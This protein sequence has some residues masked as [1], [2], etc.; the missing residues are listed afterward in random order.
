MISNSPWRRLVGIK[1]LLTDEV[2]LEEQADSVDLVLI[3][4]EDLRR[5]EALTLD[6][7]Q[8]DGPRQEELK[9]LK[10]PTF[11]MLVVL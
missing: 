4:I 6:L 2:D 7:L 10:D 9:I 8:E 3:W 11:F 5:F 1:L